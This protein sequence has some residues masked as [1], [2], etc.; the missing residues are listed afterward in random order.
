MRARMTPDWARAT[1]WSRLLVIG[2]AGAAPL[3]AHEGLH[4]QIEAVSKQIAQQPLD[5]RLYVRRGE[6]YRL[7]EDWKSALSDFDRAGE[8]DPGL[9]A[10]P[11]L[12]GRTRLEAGDAD[13][14]VPLL[15]A[16]LHDHPAEGLALLARAR[17]YA[18]LG[19]QDKAAR[20][21]AAATRLLEPPRPEHYLEW[22]RALAQDQRRT[23]AAL[24]AI[25]AGVERLGPLVTLQLYAIELERRLGRVEQAL[26][27]VKTISERARRQE[28]WHA[29]RGE[30]LSSAGRGPEAAAAYR[31]A[32]DA[33]ERLPTRRRT[34]VAVRE[35]KA[36]IQAELKRLSNARQDAPAE[37][38]PSEEGNE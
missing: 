23:M 14:A 5:A 10:L 26:K 13:A 12:K 19:R 18:A 17:A 27:R 2:L 32:L 9:A 31:A 34:V 25:D 15:N 6:L 36:H 3:A 35:L 20:D 29:L 21:W 8:L 38:P 4:E 22:A 28:R 16:Y 7:H 1:C 33:I 11:F 37:T 30:I 24:A